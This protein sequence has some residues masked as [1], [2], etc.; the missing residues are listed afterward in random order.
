[1]TA[2]CCGNAP[3]HR[4]GDKL[5]EVQNWNKVLCPSPELQLVRFRCHI[6]SHPGLLMYNDQQTNSQSGMGTL[7][8]LLIQALLIQLHFS[9]RCTMSRSTLPTSQIVLAVEACDYFPE[10]YWCGWC[11]AAL[12]GAMHSCIYTSGN[13]LATTVI[14]YSLPW[15]LLSLY[16]A[17]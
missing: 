4:F 16:L 1:M 6:C 11:I 13:T 7:R 9:I 3:S 12:P 2:N 10:H 17:G 5:Q 14:H 8:Y 15:S